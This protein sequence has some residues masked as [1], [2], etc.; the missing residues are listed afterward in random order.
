MLKAASYFIV[1]ASVTAIL[2]LGKPF[3]VPMVL[4]L[5]IW[6][7]INA[8]YQVLQTWSGERIPTWLGLPISGLLIITLLVV[9]GDVI[10]R[11]INGIIS[12][13]SLNEIDLEAHIRNVLDWVGYKGELSLEAI[14]ST[15]DITQYLRPLINSITGLA[16]S[17]LLILIYVI[18]LLVEQGTFSRKVSNLR[19]SDSRRQKVKHI[20]HHTN[21]AIRKYLVV[22]TFTSFL[23][24]FL[25]F[26]VITAFGI[27]HAFFW[28]FLIFILNFIPTLGSIVATAFPAL[29]GL[30]QYDSP[31]MFVLVFLVVSGIQLLVGNIIEPRLMGNSL[32]ISPL[33]VILSLVFWGFMWGIVGMLLCVPI[34]VSMII[35][36]AQFPATRP[37][38][39]LLSRTGE[40]DLPV[41]PPKLIRPKKY[42]I[43]DKVE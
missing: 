1:I 3:L 25:S 34:T 26:F 41:A 27:N 4:A 36:F 9:L 18:F 12:D 22:K 14:T 29:Q 15:S 21:Q 24:A 28:A 13:A 37:V 23:T 5:L 2:I 19:M 39:V 30:I 38:A 32:N 8:L 7:L 20:I 16:S 33:V 6:Y 17:S 10:T 40:V 11:N 31:S 42:R 43:R 35:V